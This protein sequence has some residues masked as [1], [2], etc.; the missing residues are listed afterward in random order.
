MDGDYFYEG[1]D[2]GFDPEYG[3]FSQAYSSSLSKNISLATDPRVANQL[4]AASDKLNTGA[5]AIELSFV[6]PDVFETIPKQHFEELNRLR[7]VVG[8]NVE[9]TLHAPLVE[10][11][12]LV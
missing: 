7:K 10:P 11:S 4:K 2:Y 5:T 12:G 8:K 6:S 9:L 1:A 3:G